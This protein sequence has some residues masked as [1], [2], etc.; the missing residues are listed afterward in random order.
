MAPL[1]HSGRKP[2]FNNGRCHRARP[3]AGNREA[4]LA[5]DSCQ[6][7]RPNRG[8]QLERR[9]PPD[10][11]MKR[12][13]SPRASKRRRPNTEAAAVSPRTLRK[14]LEFRLIGY[15]TNNLLGFQGTNDG[16]GH[17]RHRHFVVDGLGLGRVRRRD[18]DRD[19]GRG[20]RFPLRHP[21][22]RPEQGR[23]AVPTPP[24]PSGG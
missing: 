11:P 9:S 20:R 23:P 21:L 10:A 18:R 7:A 14:R 15:G 3:C 1:R 19:P 13:A 6:G 22:P 5:S 12:H 4:S 16:N 24:T 2:H 17:L 8:D